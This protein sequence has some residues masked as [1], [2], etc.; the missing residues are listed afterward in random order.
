MDYS[1]AKQNSPLTI[2]FQTIPSKIPRI[3]ATSPVFGRGIAL[4]FFLQTF[5]DD[6]LVGIGKDAIFSLK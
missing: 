4:S 6:D 1:I 2:H 3:I 5:K